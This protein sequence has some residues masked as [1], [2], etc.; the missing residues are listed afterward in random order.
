VLPIIEPQF[1]KRNKLT[2]PGAVVKDVK[3][4][5]FADREFYYLRNAGGISNVD[6]NGNGFSTAFLTSRAVTSAPSRFM[7]A[8]AISAPSRANRRSTSALT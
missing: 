8:T 3:M 2:D 7:S 5:Q 1:Q 6:R 4:V